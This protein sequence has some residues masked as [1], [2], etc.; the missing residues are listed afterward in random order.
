MEEVTPYIYNRQYLEEI[1]RD[2]N[3]HPSI[4]HSYYAH[5]K[6]KTD[7]MAWV[8]ARRF[9]PSITKSVY[10]FINPWNSNKSIDEIAKKLKLE[11]YN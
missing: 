2:N 1:A 9:M 11:M 4:I 8:R 5:A 10:K 3:V 7:R 6:A